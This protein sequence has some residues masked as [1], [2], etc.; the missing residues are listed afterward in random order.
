MAMYAL[1]HHLVRLV[2]LETARRQPAP[3]TRVSFVNAVR[4]L[5]TAVARDVPLAMRFNADRR[6]RAERRV[7]NR[8][9]TAISRLIRPRR[10]LCKRLLEKG[11]RLNF[12]RF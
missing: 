12:V 7:V 5:A 3:V 11:M 2:I 6:H 8:L 10:A 9:T 4:W 1:V